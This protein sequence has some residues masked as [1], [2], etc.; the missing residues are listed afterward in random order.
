MEALACDASAD[1]GLSL[2]KKLVHR[3]NPYPDLPEFSE[4]AQEPSPAPTVAVELAQLYHANRPFVR[5]P[6]IP[7]PY[8]TFSETFSYGV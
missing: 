2:L 4:L 3:E 8:R 7:E 5:S 1:G 6:K